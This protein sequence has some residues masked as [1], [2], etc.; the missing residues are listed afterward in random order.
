MEQNVCAALRTD[1]DLGSLECNIV[2]SHIIDSNV[3][4]LQLEKHLGFSNLK[5]N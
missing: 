3:T 1:L 4:N 2:F 5:K